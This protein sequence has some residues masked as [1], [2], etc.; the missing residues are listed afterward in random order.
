[1]CVFGTVVVVVVVVH[2][3][4]LVSPPSLN[5]LLASCPSTLIL[6][7]ALGR[8]ILAKIQSK[9]A[10]ADRREP[11]VWLLRVLLQLAGKEGTISYSI[12]FGM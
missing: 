10:K 4:S 8:V 7:S 12:L 5:C 1:M 6:V 2:F 3:G 11:T 9:V